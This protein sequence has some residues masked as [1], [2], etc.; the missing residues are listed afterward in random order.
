M[1]KKKET[2][3]EIPKPEVITRFVRTPFPGAKVKVYVGET[4][5]FGIVKEVIVA[6]LEENLLREIAVLRKSNR[7]FKLTEC[8]YFLSDTSV[9][10]IN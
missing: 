1:K 9:M 7:I 3:I 8:D 6:K 10:F 5:V 2:P 4:S